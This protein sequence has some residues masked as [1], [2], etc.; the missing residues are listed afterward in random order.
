MD[1]TV[2][3]FPGGTAHQGMKATLLMT[4]SFAAYLDAAQSEMVY[5]ELVHP[6]SVSPALL[7]SLLQSSKSR[8][9]CN[10]LGLYPGGQ[11]WGG[12]GGGVLMDKGLALGLCRCFLCSL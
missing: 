12:G 1:V 6:A 3:V 10:R 11:G 8:C 7:P 5:K 2:L 4:N 9:G